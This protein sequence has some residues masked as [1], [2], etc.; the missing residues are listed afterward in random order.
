MRYAAY[1]SNLHPARLQKRTG[2]AELL[3]TAALTDMELRFHKRGNLDGS[4]KGNIIK[5]AGRTV[6][7]AVFEVSVP[8][9]EKLDIAE[10]VGSGYEKKWIEV[11]EF[12]RCLTYLA[13]NS[14]IDDN[15]KPFTWYKDLVL[16]GCGYHGFPEEYV[17]TITNQQAVIDP[18]P[19][20][21]EDHMKL[22]KRLN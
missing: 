18:H 3:G 5:R 4:G 15:L 21:H 14:H 8:G 16:V 22:V 10:G 12:G 13:Q 7:V 17:E 19:E 11:P 20:R 6:H 1:G 2:P 9:I